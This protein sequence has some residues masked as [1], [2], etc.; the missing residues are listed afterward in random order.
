MVALLNFDDADNLVN[1]EL[2]T[3]PAEVVRYSMARD[4]A[5]HHAIPYQEFA[6]GLA[7]KTQ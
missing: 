3:E 7:A 6:V 5:M 2:I 1:V 4:A